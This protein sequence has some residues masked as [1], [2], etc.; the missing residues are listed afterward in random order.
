MR[1]LL[2]TLLLWCCTNAWAHKPSDAYLFVVADGAQLSARLDVAL[3]DLDS[4]L[5]LDANGDREL[6]W[7]EVTQKLPQIT[8]LL[9]GNLRITRGDQPCDLQWGSFVTQARSDGNYLVTTASATCGTYS[10]PVAFTYRL[11]A[12]VDVTHRAILNATIDGQPTLAVLDPSAAR[13]ST[14]NAT[15]HGNF[16][17]FVADGIHHILIGWD[18]ILFLLCLILPCVLVRDGAAWRAAPSLAPV[19]KRIALTVT[20]FTLAHS[21]TLALAAFE[22][23]RLPPRLIES[24]I[25]ATVI[26]AAANNIIALVRE[27]FALMALLFGFIHGFGFA[28]VLAELALPRERFA[29]A[30]I[31]FN[32]GVELGQLLIVSAAL[33]VVYP[34]RSTR[35]YAPAFLHGGSVAAALLASVWLVER[36][37]DWPILSI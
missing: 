26:F 1:R 3:R 7:G 21:V 32:L 18:H 17:S 8:A 30:L 9:A 13:S 10:Q 28:N 5:D 14:V 4:A 35:C 29:F 2:F 34:L 31:A 15:A 6:T 19:V 25:A 37:F 12:D 36:V 27:R 33:L 22:I 20:A 23:V 11:F 16:G 24:L